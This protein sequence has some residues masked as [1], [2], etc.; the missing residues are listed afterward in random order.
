MTLQLLGVNAI[1]E[2]L[3]HHIQL[4]VMVQS[5][6]SSSEFLEVAYPVTFNI[7]TFRV[8]RHLDPDSNFPDK[9]MKVAK[10]T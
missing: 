6:V 3:R 1:K 9:L 10:P 8:K 7:V 5:L 2:R 4:G